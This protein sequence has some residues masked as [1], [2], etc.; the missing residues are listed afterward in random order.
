VANVYFSSSYRNAESFAF[1]AISTNPHSAKA[2][3]NYGAEKFLQGNDLE[4]LR[5]LN[6]S[7]RIC[8]N[9]MP[10][11]HYRARIFRNRGMNREALA[12]LDTIFSVD[13]EY[14]AAD[15]LL[16][17][18]IKRDLNDDDGA[19]KD[20]ESALRLNPCLERP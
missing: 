6:R 2:F 18:V 19:E 14:D 17:G 13:P 12:D 10:A 4:A 16:R 5:Y 9:F 1:R 15:Y 20:F 8:S 7:V 3:A 11:L